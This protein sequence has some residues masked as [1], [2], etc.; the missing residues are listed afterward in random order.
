MP[1]EHNIYINNKKII[2]FKTS[3]DKV[4]ENKIIEGIKLADEESK[5]LF[6]IINHKEKKNVNKEKKN[7]LIKS[8]V[9]INF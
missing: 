7:Y 1:L 6:S 4:W 9:L 5:K 2:T 3:D 8:K